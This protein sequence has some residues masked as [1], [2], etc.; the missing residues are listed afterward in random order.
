MIDLK[1]YNF[2]QE[3]IDLLAINLAKLTDADPKLQQLQHQAQQRQLERE[4]LR[5]ARIKKYN[6][7][8]ELEQLLNNYPELG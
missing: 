4:D 2:L 3:Q 6:L 1:H 8:A 7:Q 5:Q